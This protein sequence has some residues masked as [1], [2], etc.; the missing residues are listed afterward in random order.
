[1]LF[2]GQGSPLHDPEWSTPTCR[3]SRQGDRRLS[4]LRKEI[5][6]NVK[7]E[8]EAQR[9]GKLA[10][11][12]PQWFCS[13]VLERAICVCVLDRTWGTWRDEGILRPAPRCMEGLRPAPGGT[14]PVCVYTGIHLTRT[15]PGMQTAQPSFPFLHR[16]RFGLA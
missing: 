14:R 8:E 6:T 7:H 9:R 4:W 5:L 1:M 2:D 16:L 13:S 10:A 11:F 3:R 15:Q 12:Q